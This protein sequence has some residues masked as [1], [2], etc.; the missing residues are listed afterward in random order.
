MFRLQTNID[1]YGLG[2]MAYMEPVT[3]RTV[4]SFKHPTVKRTPVC[5]L[6]PAAD[7]PQIVLLT[8]DGA[9]TSPTGVQK[10]I[11]LP[12]TTTPGR[13]CSILCLRLP[14]PL[15]LPR[16]SPRPRSELT[17]EPFRWDQRLFSISLQLPSR[18]GVGSGHW[19]TLASKTTAMCEVTGGACARPLS[20]LLL[21]QPMIAG[22]SFQASS[23]KLLLH[24]IEAIA[25]KMRPGVVVN[26]ECIDTLPN[27][28][29]ERGPMDTDA[30][31]QCLHQLLSV[32]APFWPLPEHYVIDSRTSSFVRR[33]L[34]PRTPLFRFLLPAFAAR[35]RCSLSH[36]ATPTSSRPSQKPRAAQ[37][38]LVFCPV[39][40]P[41]SYLIPRGF[42]TTIFPVARCSLTYFMLAKHPGEF[43]PVRPFES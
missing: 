4:H 20:V 22:M 18:E 11:S 2:R 28:L 43:W 16:D 17:V 30:P 5:A 21:I 24:R 23:M 8:D 33:S 42:P 25:S 37:P 41:S 29:A 3:V 14:L 40:A 36:S 15:L 38:T 9:L 27:E 13:C 31:K 32:S 35:P 10:I 7:L 26:F 34:S 1:N 6:R 19:E 12:N 39:A